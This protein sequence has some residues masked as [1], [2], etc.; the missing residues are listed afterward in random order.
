MTGSWPY[1]SNR[2]PLH[3][4]TRHLLLHPESVRF[5]ARGSRPDSPG[6][7]H[8][9]AARRLAI[10]ADAPRRIGRRSHERLKDEP[11][12]GIPCPFFYIHIIHPLSFI[13]SF[14]SLHAMN[15]IAADLQ[16]GRA[17]V[18]LPAPWLGHQPGDRLARVGSL[19]PRRGGPRPRMR[20]ILALVTG[21]V[22]PRPW[23]S[24][25]EA[26]RDGR[27]LQA[28]RAGSGC[29]LSKF[30][31]I[32]P[33]GPVRRAYPQRHSAPRQFQLG[34]CSAS[35]ERKTALLPAS[36]GWATS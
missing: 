31:C 9:D 4:I 17:S 19:Q 16:S 29:D 7:A 12:P 1:S 34:V 30:R 32:E 13:L 5:I 6:D 2:N 33:D 26:L 20:K 21:A 27:P 8:P 24:R 36:R 25:P 11:V 3:E 14:L 23:P 15:P 18:T 10:V 28:Q 35:G 22:S